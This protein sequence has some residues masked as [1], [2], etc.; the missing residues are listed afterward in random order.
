MT[1]DLGPDPENARVSFERAI[2]GLEF[3]KKHGLKVR[4]HV[5][6]WHDQTPEAFFFMRIMM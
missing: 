4:G 1:G 6:I 5:L 2:P 3:A